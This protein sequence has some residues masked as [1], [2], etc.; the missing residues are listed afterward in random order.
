[1][2]LP[3]WEE[4]MKDQ[5]TCRVVR[6]ESSYKGRQGLTYFAGI[7]AESVGSR[8]LCMHLL[9]MPPGAR[10]KAHLHEAHETAIHVL[11]GQAGMWYGERLEHHLTVQPG[12][13]L[14]IPAGVPHLPYNPGPDEAVAVLSRTDPNEQE[15]VVLCPDLDEVHPA[16]ARAP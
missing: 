14:Y 11:S 7:S 5:D 9:R 4:R 3:D 1:M 2:P 16:P 10:A 6:G 8:G 15:S 12:D 13:Y